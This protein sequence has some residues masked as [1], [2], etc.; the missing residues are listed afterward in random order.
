[1]PTV[2]RTEAAEADLREIAY[3]IGIRDQRPTIADRIID[4]LVEQCE[5]LARNSEVSLQG[6]AAPE[7]GNDVRLLSY[8][9]WVIIFRYQPHGVD[10]LRFA[11]GSQ[12]YLSWRL[13]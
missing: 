6:T 9:R 8:S 3:Q 2:R 12:D 13:A 5:P 10:V 4:E 7:L 11:D 1:M